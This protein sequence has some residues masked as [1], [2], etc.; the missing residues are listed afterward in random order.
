MTAHLACVTSGCSAC[1]IAC[2]I[3]GCMDLG[4]GLGGGCD[5]GITPM[6]WFRIPHELLH[7]QLHGVEQRGEISPS[8]VMSTFNS[9]FHASSMPALFHGV[10]NSL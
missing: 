2:G 1:G 5:S 7:V 4:N 10:R 6:G 9:L 3:P 8:S